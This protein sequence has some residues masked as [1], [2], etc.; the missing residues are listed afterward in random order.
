MLVYTRRVSGGPVQPQVVLPYEL[1]EKN[2]LLVRSSSGETVS[3]ILPRES[4]PLRD[5]E[6]LGTDGDDELRIVAA[7]EALLE[8]RADEPFGLLRAAYH[9]GNRHVRM[10][11][12][13]GCLWIPYDH[14][15]EDLLTSMRV[16]TRRLERPFNPE[17]GAYGGGHHHSHGKDVDE[18]YA[19]RI[20]EYGN[21]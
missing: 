1:R 5:G 8:I 9:L 3:I 15:L 2:R 11:I 20:H 16:E 14:V 12:A 4:E 13:A 19:P 7:H 17:R 18:R 10:E 21:R 6:V